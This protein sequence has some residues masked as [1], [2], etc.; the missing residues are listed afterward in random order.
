MDDKAFIADIIRRQIAEGVTGKLNLKLLTSDERRRLEEILERHGNVS[1]LGMTENGAVSFRDRV[2]ILSAFVA[3]VVVIAI[4]LVSTRYM[5]G[6]FYSGL[7][8]ITAIAACSGYIL[9]RGLGHLLEHG[10]PSWQEWIIR[11]RF[12]VAAASVV[13][14]LP[15]L[16]LSR[17]LG[18][19][20]L[21]GGYYLGGRYVYY[22]AALILLFKVLGA[23]AVGGFVIHRLLAW[24]ISGRKSPHDDA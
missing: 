15:V 12:T 9:G 1:Q 20:S 14:A 24:T 4:A 23:S 7:A 6:S 16:L 10:T 5:R 21:F 8:F 13:V 3:A 2:A 19:G 17:S 22:T 11:D 18:I